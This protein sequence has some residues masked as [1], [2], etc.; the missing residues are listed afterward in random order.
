MNYDKKE[1]ANTRDS[2]PSRREHHQDS[3]INWHDSQ[4]PFIERSLSWQRKNDCR[5]ARQH[6]SGASVRRSRLSLSSLISLDTSSFSFEKTRAEMLD[7]LPSSVDSLPF[8]VTP[9]ANLV[10]SID[11]AKPVD[12]FRDQNS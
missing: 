5:R 7:T 12:G 2:L 10:E 1:N 9:K 4:E 11:P 3:P 8:S 6:G